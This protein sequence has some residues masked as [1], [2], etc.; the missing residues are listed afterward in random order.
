MSSRGELGGRGR[1]SVGG[2]AVVGL[3]GRRA[4]ADPLNLAR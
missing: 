4:S 3:A 2:K 1:E